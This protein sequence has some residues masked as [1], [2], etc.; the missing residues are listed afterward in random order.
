MAVELLVGLFIGVSVLCMF[1]YAVRSAI[2]G[3]PGQRTIGERVPIWFFYTLACAIAFV[4][5]VGM[6]FGNG[7]E[8]CGYDPAIAQ[9][10]KCSAT[11]ETLGYSLF[12][13]GLAVWTAGVLWL[14]GRALWN[15]GLPRSTS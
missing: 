9:S 12:W 11:A 2:S 6:V 4:F 15:L 10:F 14:L 7:A 1:V 5:G 8:D 3:A 13:E